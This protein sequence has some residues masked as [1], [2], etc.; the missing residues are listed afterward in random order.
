MP[1]LAAKGWSGTGRSRL[2]D[3]GLSPPN[4]HIPGKFGGYGLGGT[5]GLVVIYY[6]PQPPAVWGPVVTRIATWYSGFCM[7]PVL[8]APDSRS[9]P[10]Q[11]WY[12]L[13]SVS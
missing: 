12:V 7:E 11:R 6:S 5:G 2:A 4:S 1:H 3:P 13:G 9:Q 10:I 8:N